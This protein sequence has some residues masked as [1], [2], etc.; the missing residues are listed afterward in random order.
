LGTAALVLGLRPRYSYL[1]VIQN[2]HRIDD[3]LLES[4]LEVTDSNVSVLPSPTLAPDAS[5]PS[6]DEVLGLLRLCQRHFPYTVVD[7][8]SA[9]SAAMAAVLRESDHSLA[10]ST[11]EIPTLR[12]LKRALEMVEGVS[13]NGASPPHIVLN[14][15]RDG[16]GV[17]VREVEDALGRS[18]FATLGWDAEA[19]VQSLNLAEPLATAGR[20]RLGRD[21]TRLGERLT[22]LS[23][24]EPGR[25]FSLF[26]RRDRTSK[27]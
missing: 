27:K 5:P 21:L 23:L 6:A 14:Q 11:P 18:V 10:L 2:F 4:F 17:S 26:K 24:K 25:G 9:P 16:T 7:A 13:M 1:D 3:E 8:G 15:Y 20:S 19:V 22:G 12:N